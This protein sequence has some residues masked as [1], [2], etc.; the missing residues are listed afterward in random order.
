MREIWSIGEIGAIN[1]LGSSVEVPA[2]RMISH[3]FLILYDPRCFKVISGGKVD[4]FG[5]LLSPTGPGNQTDSL[6][7]LSVLKKSTKNK[8]KYK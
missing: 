1:L 2:D 4:I 5:Y 6:K 8:D 3:S 7:N